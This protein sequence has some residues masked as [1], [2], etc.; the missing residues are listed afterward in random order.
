MIGEPKMDG[1]FFT[2]KLHLKWMILDKHSLRIGT[3]TKNRFR[4]EFLAT[5]KFQ[6]S[7]PVKKIG[8]STCFVTV[9][10]FFRGSFRRKLGEKVKVQLPSVLSQEMFH[11]TK[12]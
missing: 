3:Q 11:Y 8:D 6:P 12:T 7:D 5:L 4:K 9:F 2:E 10:G 1:L